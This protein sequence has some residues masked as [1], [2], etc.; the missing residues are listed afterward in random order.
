MFPQLYILEGLSCF[1]VKY[2]HCPVEDKLARV[3]V[4]WGS[5][6]EDEVRCVW[7]RTLYNGFSGNSEW[8]GVIWMCASVNGFRS[9]VLL[10]VT[11]REWLM[12]PWI[13]CLHLWIWCIHL[14]SWRYRL[15][16]AHPWILR[17]HLQ[18]VYPCKWWCQELAIFAL[19]SAFSTLWGATV[20]FLVDGLPQNFV[21]SGRVVPLLE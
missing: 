11:L 13:W 6:W 17:S 2:R 12:H 20:G 14:C 9:V 5:L 8:L 18:V 4:Y 19:F 1:F 15:C 16:N 21:Q 7:V 10:E 3:T